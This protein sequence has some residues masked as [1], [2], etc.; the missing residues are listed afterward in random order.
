MVLRAHLH[1]VSPVLTGLR[2]HI[3]L[4]WERDFWDG[5]VRSPTFVPPISLRSGPYVAME[6]KQVLTCKF[7]GN[8]IK[9]SREM[10]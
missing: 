5:R 1:H 10:K 7:G 9:I 2:V 8:L 6:P 4:A 3:S